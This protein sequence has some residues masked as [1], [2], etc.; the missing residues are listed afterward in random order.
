MADSKFLTHVDGAGQ[1]SM[2]DVSGKPRVRRT[3][4]A[5]CS[6]HLAASTVAL[7]KANSL[8]K[9]DVLATA[10][11]A[12]IMAGKKTAELIPLCHNIEIDRIAVEFTVHADRIDIESLAVCTDKTGIEMEALT[13]ASVA[14]LTIYDMCKAVDKAMSIDKLHLLEKTKEAPDARIC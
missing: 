7:I 8:A 10:R 3:A 13:A 2:V 12:G 1:A 5:A 9:G 4:R 6:V 11:I 14:A